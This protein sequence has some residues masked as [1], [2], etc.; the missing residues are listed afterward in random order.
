MPRPENL[1]GR[2]G[3]YVTSDVY[4]IAERLWELGRAVNTKLY[5]SHLDP[6]VT[7]FGRTYHF[8]ISEIGEDGVERFVKRVQELDARCVTDCERMLHIPFE[9]RFVEAEK[10]EEKW[11]EEEKERQ[12]DELYERMGGNMRI[13]LERC[14]FIDPWGPKYAPMNRTARRHRRYH[15]NAAVRS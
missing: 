4:H 5:V 12:L 9:K 11:A 10:L 7:Q 1:R 2:F 14:N 6:P 3:T 13:Q 15:P 8:C